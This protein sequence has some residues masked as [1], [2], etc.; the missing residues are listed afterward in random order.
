MASRSAARE[1]ALAF[2]P[3]LGECNVFTTPLAG[4]YFFFVRAAV[5]APA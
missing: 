4:H 2:S 3:S 5:F 1:E